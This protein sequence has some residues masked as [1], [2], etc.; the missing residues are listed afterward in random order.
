MKY[1]LGVDNGGTSTK[2][3]LYDALGRELA[4][5]SRDTRVLTPAPDWFER[6]M[7]EMWEANCAVIREVL[8][9]SG[10]SPGEVAGVA[11]CGHGKGLYLWGKDGHPVRRGIISA[12]N[13]AWKYYSDWKADGT[14][15]KASEMFAELLRC[16]WYF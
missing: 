2:A 3:A 12:D 11:V 4:V 13:R 6:D 16:V 10:V 15:E 1:Y 14:E 9:L 7:E 8:R 5:S